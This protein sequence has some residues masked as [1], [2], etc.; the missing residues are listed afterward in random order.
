MQQ[1]TIAYLASILLLAF[2]IIYIVSNNS[3]HR[4][5]LELM[6]FELEK[7]KLL[8][9]SKDQLDKDY[10]IRLKQVEYDK[11]IEN[12]DFMFNVA[13]ED[14]NYMLKMREIEMK[15]RQNQN[16]LMEV[17]EQNKDVQFR[18]KK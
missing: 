9:F 4:K 11:A 6:K 5:K 10:D 3:S 12:R 8:E 17:I 2:C 15:E 13:K 7:Y 1:I 18:I 16:Q 14:R